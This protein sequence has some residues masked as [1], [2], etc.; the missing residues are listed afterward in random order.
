MVPAPAIQPAPP[1]APLI[2]ASFDC[3]AA[4]SDVERLIC[5][6]NQLAQLD[7]RV[8][9]MY[10]RGLAMVVDQNVFRG[11]QQVFLSDRDACMDKQCLAVAYEARIKDL[12]RW[13]TP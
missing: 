8:A 11:E 9:D 12:L 5:S 4:S 3:S 7:I 6:D 13:V 1:P 2:Q 10:R